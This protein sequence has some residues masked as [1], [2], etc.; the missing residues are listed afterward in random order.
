MNTWR[1]NGITWEYIGFVDIKPIQKSNRALMFG[2]RFIVEKNDDITELSAISNHKPVVC[3]K[4]VLSWEPDL[5]VREIAGECCQTCGLFVA[6]EEIP[7]KLLSGFCEKCTYP[8]L[9]ARFMD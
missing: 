6:N 1:F 2:D 3:G 4:N 7:Y 9:W 5:K 8:E